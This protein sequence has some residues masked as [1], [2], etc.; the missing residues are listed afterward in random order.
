MTPTTRFQP[1]IEI[2]AEDVAAPSRG[3][4]RH[5]AHSGGGS[6]GGHRAGS[7][8][9]KQR[10]KRFARSGAGKSGAVILFLV[11]V[12]FAGWRAMGFFGGESNDWQR[13][14]YMNP[15]TGE[16]TWVYVGGN[17]PAGFHPVEYCFQNQCGPAGGTP[18]VLNV[19]MGKHERTLCPKCGARVVGHNPRPDE[20]ASAIPIDQQR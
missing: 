16:L 20:Y 7:E 3:G 14:R 8:G 10:L 9:L 11:V 6:A 17:A 1:L 5:S 4:S 2:E 12:G 15:D 18:V 19:Y 13:Y